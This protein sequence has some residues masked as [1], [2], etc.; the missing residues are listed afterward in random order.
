ML[1]DLEFRALRPVGKIFKVAHQRGL[2]VAVA[3]S[4]VVSFRF[5]YRLNGRRKTLVQ[6]ARHRSLRFATACTRR[7]MQRH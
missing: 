2:Y 5:D 7:A 3:S 6:D 4:R 1:T